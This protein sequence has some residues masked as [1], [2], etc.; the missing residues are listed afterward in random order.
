MSKDIYRIID[1]TTHEPVASGFATREAAK[2]RRDE[3]NGD[4]PPKDGKPGRYI[5]S[6]GEDHPDGPTN[7]IHRRMRGKNSNW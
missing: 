6:R 3:L 5:V 4:H 1:T 7:G 2:P